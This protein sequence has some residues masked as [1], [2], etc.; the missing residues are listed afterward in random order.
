MKSC[1]IEWVRVT[2]SFVDRL[3][4]RRVRIE[5]WRPLT[6]S[7]PLVSLLFKNHFFIYH[8]IL[9]IVHHCFPPLYFHHYISTL[10]KLIAACR[11]DRTPFLPVKLQ[12]VP[13]IQWILII[14]SV[15][16]NVWFTVIHTVECF[17]YSIHLATTWTP[18]LKWPMCYILVVL[19]TWHVVQLFK[20]KP[21]FHLT[22]HS[23]REGKAC[24]TFYW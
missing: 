11:N 3:Q 16:N 18:N 23:S 8:Y 2:R 6:I 14:Y 1:E 15:R 7:F 10:A 9:N 5:Y 19:T 20:L 17:E 22:P 21:R 13:W 24:R 4:N 12:W